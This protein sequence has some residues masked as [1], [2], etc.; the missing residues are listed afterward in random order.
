MLTFLIQALLFVN[1][2]YSNLT[3]KNLSEFENYNNTFTEI[4]KEYDDY[5]NVN[6]NDKY[7]A[8]II[9]LSIQFLI[10]LCLV[11]FIRKPQD[12]KNNKSCTIIFYMIFG[13]I[14]SS[15]FAFSLYFYYPCKNRYSDNFLPN[16]YCFSKKMDTNITH[17]YNNK[18]EYIIE[19][20]NYD[21]YPKLKEIYEVYYFNKSSHEIKKCKLDY[22]TLGIFYFILAMIEMPAFA[23]ISFILLIISK[24]K[25]KCQKVFVVFEIFSLELKLFVI[26]WPFRKLKMKYNK[27][28]DNSNEEI[29]YIIEDYQIILNVKMKFSIILLIESFYIFLDIITFCATFCGKEEDKKNNEIKESIIDINSKKEPL[30]K[31]EKKEEIKEPEN[32]SRIIVIQHDRI[33]T[34]EIEHQFVNLKFKDNKNHIYELEVDSKRRFND[35]LNELIGKYD[36]L[37]KNEIKSVIYNNRFLYLAYRRCFET[38]EELKID[39]NS[40]YIYIEVE[41]EQV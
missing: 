9:L 16:K 7:T 27:N 14:T 8:I 28:I 18:S 38:I 30:I 17:F 4:L 41:E 22:E 39:E 29:Q 32:N 26:F 31:E 19:E 34:K 12:N 3:K 23:L 5:K 37:R 21:H 1:K 40:D 33:I 6:S 2:I 35:I 11:I 13:F 15:V 10:F 25:N 20:Y 24:C 36:Y